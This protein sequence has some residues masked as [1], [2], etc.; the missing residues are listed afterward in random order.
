MKV[1]QLFTLF[2]LCSTFS[3]GQ[4]VF[5]QEIDYLSLKI[6]RLEST[7]KYYQD[8]IKSIQLSIKEL[9]ITKVKNLDVFEAVVKY[10]V[11]IT[12]KDDYTKVIGK[13]YKGDTVVLGDYEW[14][15][16]FATNGD[17]LGLINVTD[18]VMTEELELHSQLMDEEFK[19]KRV[20]KIESNKAKNEA[21]VRAANARR[22]ANYSNQK[23]ARE[24][25]RKKNIESKFLTSEGQ[26]ITNKIIDRKV[27]VGMTARMASYSIGK[28]KK[29]NVTE[30]GYGRKEQWVYNGAYYSYLYFTNNQLTAIQYS[31]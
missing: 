25:A 6:V 22:K 26:L 21:A 3:F 14:N 9:K 13:F 30:T 18:L 11:K 1:S 24:A 28:P 31:K 4:D 27:W 7:I 12:A 10:D 16:F 20:Q 29:I 8:S 17:I 15:Q 19:K 23:A 2:I 5:D